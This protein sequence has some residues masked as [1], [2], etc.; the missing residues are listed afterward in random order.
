MSIPP[1][2]LPPACCCRG[3]GKSYFANSPLDLA[4]VPPTVN[5]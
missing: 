2:L 1:I 3:T 5:G 4:T